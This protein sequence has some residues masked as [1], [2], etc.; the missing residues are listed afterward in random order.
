MKMKLIPRQS[1]VIL[2]NCPMSN[3]N[4]DPDR[5]GS[6][7]VLDTDMTGLITSTSFTRKIRNLIGD[8]ESMLWQILANKFGIKPE[9]YHVYEQK[10]ND[11]IVIQA[12]KSG[13]FMASF[14]DAR[15]K[16][17]TH[18]PESEEKRA[19][20]KAKGKKGK[21]KEDAP[22]APDAE[23][24]VPLDADTF[25]KVIFRGP[26]QLGIGQTMRPILINEISET[27]M[28]GT[29]EG[30]QSGY[31]M[32]GDKRV[33]HGM[34]A[35]R[36]NFDPNSVDPQAMPFIETDIKVFKAIVPLV[37]KLTASKT[38]PEVSIPHAYH[39]T[40]KSPLG[41]DSDEKMHKFLLPTTKVNP[42]EPSKSIDDY[43][44]ADLKAFMEKFRVA[45]IEDLC[46]EEHMLG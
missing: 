17:C 27:K 15:L 39:I 10:D 11:E 33:V 46:D 22:D 4:G 16:G 34:Y 43:T 21:T 2:I 26:L 37:Y 13:M 12:K 23:I 18:L 40:H 1:G 14:F 19:K 41:S 29:T 44:F 42:K 38:R 5:S 7:R 6:P 45:S 20:A 30:K 8:K 3:P 31:A 24:E 28:R 25:R 36:Y 32:L 9:N 35:M